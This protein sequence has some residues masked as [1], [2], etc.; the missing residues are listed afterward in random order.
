MGCKTDLKHEDIIKTNEIKLQ[1][2]LS[3]ELQLSK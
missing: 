2:N 3:F 1:N